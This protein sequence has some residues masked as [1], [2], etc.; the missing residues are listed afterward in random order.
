[1][2]FIHGYRVYR[3]NKCGKGDL[4]PKVI[5]E[6]MTWDSP[7]VIDFDGYEECWN[8]GNTD[9]DYEIPEDEV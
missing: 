2:H 4:I 1:M 3:C 5:Y 9:P 8:C 6:P 7:E